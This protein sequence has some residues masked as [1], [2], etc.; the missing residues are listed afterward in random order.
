MKQ[1]TYLMTA[2]FSAGNSAEARSIGYTEEGTPPLRAAD[3]G[4]NQ[5]P[6]IVST[7]GWP[8]ELPAH[9]D[10]AG[11]LQRGGDGGRHDGVMTPE[12]QVRRLTPKEC[13]RLQGFPDAYLDIPFKGK[14]ATDGHK[15]KA[16]GNSMAVP[17]MWYIGEQIQKATSIDDLI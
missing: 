7:I 3:S 11:T 17:V 14:P 15:Y 6:T 1:T 16:L 9:Q 5:V 2:A 8:E 13:A 4:T 10:L 12:L